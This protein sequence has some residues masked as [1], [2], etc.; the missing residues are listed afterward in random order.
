MTLEICT[1]SYQSAKNAQVA[2]AHRIELCSALSVGGITPSYGLIACAVNSLDMDIFVLIRPRSGDFSYS[3][4][5]FKIIKKDIE[6]CK[7]LGCDGIVSGVLNKDHT[8]DVERTK[9]LIELS[10]PMAFTFHRAFD[11]VPNPMDTLEQLITIGADRILTS[12]Q[13]HKAINGLNLLLDLK[14]QA[15]N[16]IIVLPGSGINSEN[17]STFKNSGF[18]EIHCSA[19][20]PCSNESLPFFGNA[21]Q[22]VSC[23]NE[24]KAILNQIS[25]EN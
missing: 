11:L 25:N 12:G 10:K 6:V 13:E 8:L 7:N 19:S 23:P 1:N 21:D 4:E 20:K 14:A 9:G 17:A 16:R 5:E 18:T 3:E 24:I 2:G 22:T 15:R